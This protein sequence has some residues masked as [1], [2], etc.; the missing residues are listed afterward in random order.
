MG[1]DKVVLLFLV[2]CNSGIPLTHV[3][4]QRMSNPSVFYPLWF[5][6]ASIMALNLE[7]SFAS[8]AAGLS[9]SKIYENGKNRT[10]MRTS[11]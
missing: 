1:Q 9:N 11:I 7:F 10:E 3:E 2:L 4:S 5:S 8:K 6:V